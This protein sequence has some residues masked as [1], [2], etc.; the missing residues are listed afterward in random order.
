MQKFQAFALENMPPGPQRRFTLSEF[1]LKALA[2]ASE[3]L[4]RTIANELM[5]QRRIAE[6]AFSKYQN[7]LKELKEESRSKIDFF[8]QK[9]RSLETERAE[10]LAKEQTLR[11]SL[12]QITREKEHLEQ[13]MTEK[14]ESLRRE[15]N[16]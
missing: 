5:L 11:E 3:F 4:V 8:E 14:L 1:C 7:E 10:V 6:E 9:L 15:S 13:D 12:A 16:R 2:E